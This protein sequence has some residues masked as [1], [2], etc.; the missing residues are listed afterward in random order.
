MKSPHLIIYSITYVFILAT[1]LKKTREL[2]SALSFSEAVHS[3]RKFA[4]ETA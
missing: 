2:P 1:N 3:P 4:D